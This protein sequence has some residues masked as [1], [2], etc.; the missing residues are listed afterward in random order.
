MP[1]LESG[2][3]PLTHT[4]RASPATVRLARMISAPWG[5]KSLFKEVKRAFVSDRISNE[6]ETSPVLY[7][8]IPWSCG[9]SGQRRCSVEDSD[10][11]EDQSVFEHRTVYAHSARE[12]RIYVRPVLLEARLDRS[13][14]REDNYY[15]GGIL[16]SMVG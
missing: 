5:N 4:T 11:R 9:G 16:G 8:R 6:Q 2:S 3:Q 13:C 1:S 12:R 14:P 15:F 7:Y 10:E